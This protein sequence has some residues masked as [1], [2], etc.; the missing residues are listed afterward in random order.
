MS[1]LIKI[2]ICIAPFLIAAYVGFSML[3]PSIEEAGLR[4]TEVNEKKAEAETLQRKI[5]DESKMQAKQKQLEAD[6]ASL[7]DSVPKSPDMDLF[8]I[9]LEKMC[10]EAGMDLI[11]IGPS[12]VDPNAPVEDKSSKLKKSQDKLKNALKA[13]GTDAKASDKDEEDAPPANELEETSRQVVVTGD[14]NG[15]QKLVHELETYQRVIKINDITSRVP[16]KETG[17]EIKLPDEAIPS[18]NEPVG[19]PNMLYISMNLTTYYLP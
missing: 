9:D 4:E 10:K 14:Y 6:I 16:K 3:Q 19:N 7:R 11:S 5:S 13:T 12:K 15:L 1:P 2:V 17:K 8:T 18:E